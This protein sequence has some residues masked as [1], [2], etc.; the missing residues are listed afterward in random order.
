MATAEGIRNF[1]ISVVF[2]GAGSDVQQ[3][4]AG[5]CTGWTPRMFLANPCLGSGLSATSVRCAGWPRSHG[6]SVCAATCLR[7]PAE[8]Q[9]YL[10]WPGLATL[11]RSH[12]WQSGCLELEPGARVLGSVGEK[13]QKA[14]ATRS[15]PS[16]LSSEQSVPWSS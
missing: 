9:S 12:A 8:V 15:R 1:D 6:T 7:L 10:R 4:C 3:P 11:Q 2:L 16:S 13:E 14:V 5:S